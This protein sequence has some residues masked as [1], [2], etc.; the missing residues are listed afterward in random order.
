MPRD[1]PRCWTR[2]ILTSPLLTHT[3]KLQLFTEQSLMKNTGTY[4]KRSSTTKNVKKELQ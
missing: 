3:S 4:Q 2:K 1:L